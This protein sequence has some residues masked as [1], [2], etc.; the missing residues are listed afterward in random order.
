MEI[1]DTDAPSANTAVENGQVNQQ[2]EGTTEMMPMTETD[3]T[4]DGELTAPGAGTETVPSINEPMGP[5]E[6]VGNEE[7]LLSSGLF[8]DVANDPLLQDYNFL[9]DEDDALDEEFHFLRVQDIDEDDEEYQEFE[10]GED[11]R[12]LLDH[13]DLGDDVDD[14]VEEREGAAAAAAAAANGSSATNAAFHDDEAD[15]ILVPKYASY[16]WYK[17][18]RQSLQSKQTPFIQYR[19]M[20]KESFPQFQDFID[21]GKKDVVAT[22]TKWK[23]LNVQSQQLHPE[24][25]STE[26]DLAGDL[27][28]WQVKYGMSAAGLNELMNI[29]GSR[30]ASENCHLPV[31]P[32]SSRKRQKEPAAVK[33]GAFVGETTSDS[34]PAAPANNHAE[35]SGEKPRYRSTIH[36]YV[37]TFESCTIKVD[38]CKTYCRAFTSDDELRCST[39]NEW[40]YHPCKD[41]KCVEKRE[42]A[43]EHV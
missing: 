19:E 36:K 11:D 7:D 27:A 33:A 18:R 43:A 8:L 39:C 17:K 5:S 21:R 42:A 3:G 10:D 9:L 2:D 26:A 22:M 1:S 40:R 28:V 4:V 35:E 12:S 15:E 25:K 24:T 14:T 31:E 13:G 16:L 41:K 34:S 23:N 30:M 20:L 38:I 6:E 32:I 37:P 29:F